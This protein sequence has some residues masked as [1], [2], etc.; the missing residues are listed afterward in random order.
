[1][2]KFPHII[3][4]V[5]LLCSFSC[6]KAIEPLSINYYTD[7]NLDKYPTLIKGMVDKAYDLATVTTYLTNEYIYM[8]C[9]TDN[10]VATSSTASMRKLANGSISP[11]EDPLKSYWQRDYNGIYYVNCFLEDD[12]G[13]NT[14]YMLD[15]DQ[16]MYLRKDYKGDAFALRAWF[17]YD[18]LSKFGGRGIDGKLY[19]VP[20]F[21]SATVQ[22]SAEPA[23]IVRE[24][25]DECVAQVIADCDSAFVYLP[26]ANRDWL[27]GNPAV[28]GSCRW[29]RFDGMSVTALKALVCLLWASPTFNPSS[30]VS[31]WEMAAE[32]AAQA[33]K[34]KLDTDGPKGF[35]SASGFSWTDPNSPEAFW[36]SRPSAT[37]STMEKSQYPNGFNGKCLYAPT[38]ELVD[39]YP[40]ANG[41]P[42]TDKRSGYNPKAPYENRDPRFYADIFFNGA[43]LLR[44][45]NGEVMYTFETYNSG[46]DV[47]GLVG[48]GLTNYY[49]RKFT[50]AGWNQSDAVA[51]TMPRA[52]IYIG[53]RDMCL[54][55]AEAANRAYGPESEHFGFTAKKALSYIRAR[56]LQDGSNGVGTTSDPYLAE[57]CRDPEMFDAL[58]RNERRIEFCFEGRRYTDL[59][60]WG[61]PLEERNQPVHRVKIIRLENIT[62]Y[63]KVVADRRNMTSIF[64]PIPYSEML[65]APSLIQ[66]EGWKSWTK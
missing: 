18:L 56:K 19:G 55:F 30:D 54:A 49:L 45:G 31:R 46:K 35:S 62:A 39:A 4:L 65:N 16:D 33:M 5:V 50:Y 37:T 13:Y 15:D 58:V 11:A 20:V 40:A 43:K 47:N 6:R 7:D 60:R 59:M 48:N 53:W 25:F 26:L 28:E 2:K 24:P 52:V 64:L 17:L 29:S 66:N 44:N 1:M 10:G 42:I 9:A 34:Y 27:A 23:S 12:K 36:I 3:L 63:S 22:A 8:D 41:Y 32:F 14:R 21:T 38:Q 57:C 51:Q 61:I